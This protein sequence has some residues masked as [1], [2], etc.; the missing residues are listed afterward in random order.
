MDARARARIL[1]ILTA[2]LCA[3]LIST[4]ASAQPQ[5][6]RTVLAIHWG[7]EEFPATPPVN[8]AIRATLMAD[9]DLPID[10]FTEYLESDRFAP[11][12]ASSAL[13]DYI[14]RKYRG[15]RIDLVMAIAD[16]ALTFVL[17]HGAELF[18]GAP[19]VYSGVALPDTIDRYA[20]GITAVMRGSAYAETLK[21]ALDLHPATERVFVI[22]KGQDH[23]TIESVRAELGD[24]WGRA[25]LTYV[26]EAT[27]P[28]LLAAVRAVPPR[29][30][31]LYIWHSQAEPGHV[32]YANE[33][34]RL[35]MQAAPV[36]VY[37]T[38]D[39]Y[40]GAGVVGGVVRGRDET[41]VRM[42]EMAR[43]ILHGTRPRDI[44]IENA[45]LVPTFDWRQLNRWHINL[46]RLPAESDIR[47]R[48]PTAWESYRSYVVGTVIV[49]LGQLLLIAGL[50]THRARRRRAEEAVRRSE[51]TLRTSYERNRHLA[52]RLI[53]A[54]ETARAQI[55]RDLHDDVCQELV[56]L[57]L[58]VNRLQRSSGRLQD[59]RAQQALSGLNERTLAVVDGVRRLSHD[60]H[61]AGLQLVGL[62][63]ALESHCIEV[64]RRHDVQVGFRREGDLEHVHPDV[65]MC[66]F[67]IVQE[68]LRN[69][70]VHGG[71]RRL[72][73]SLV[74]SQD[75]IELT[76]S[77]DGCGFDLEAVRGAG[78][79]L[80]LVSM[81]ERAHMVGGEVHVATR[82]QHG[83]TVCV[84]VPA[85]A[86][87]TTLP[88]RSHVELETQAVGQ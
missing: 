44:P 45:R 86:S 48:L 73:V 41:A 76:V 5:S 65:A 12:E 84:R 42:A 40:I 85:G 33:V 80:G 57:S 31:V 3:L 79:G 34:L 6:V 56:G 27:V 52:G 11:D 67:R 54:Q 25:A 64:E 13:A 10:Y 53:N 71:A 43:Q 24:A 29:S 75:D 8:E 26:E 55:A 37:G 2:T 74:R 38:N 7:P 63:G 49:V 47:F 16:P 23:R 4:S 21:L 58:A 14:R 35:V 66:V 15:R 59:T 78:S 68:A 69:G 17:A 36:P 72:A 20:A 88:A 39:D 19:I 46:S 18:P 50:L 60:L 1:P 9:A 70:A 30:L 32:M 51:A 81:E 83:T 62:A 61:P 87:I 77:D 82:P 22:A 28:G